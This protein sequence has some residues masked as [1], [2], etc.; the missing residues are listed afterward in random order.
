VKLNGDI[1]DP[2]CPNCIRSE[3]FV[4]DILGIM[5]LFY[6]QRPLRVIDVGASKKFQ[7]KPTLGMLLG[8]Y[9]LPLLKLEFPEKMKIV[10][11]VLAFSH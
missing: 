5:A 6:Y 9:Y 7:G 4:K 2:W 8:Y 10:C 11:W 3:K 1:D